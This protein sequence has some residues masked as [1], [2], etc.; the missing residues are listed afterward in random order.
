MDD[1][2]LFVKIGKIESCLEAY[3]ESLDRIET[4]VAGLEPIKQKVHRHETLFKA[5]A[6]FLGVFSTYI[7]AKGSW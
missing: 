1:K 5:A 3:K 2:E 6:W 4:A 7:L